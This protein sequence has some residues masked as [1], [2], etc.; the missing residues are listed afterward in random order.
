MTQA[1]AP[2]AMQWQGQLREAE[3]RAEDLLA[4]V[5]AGLAPHLAKELTHNL[6][7]QLAYQR[8]TLLRAHRLAE[9]E[10]VALEMR[11]DKVCR[12]LQ[13]RVSTYEKRTAEL[14]KELVSKTEQTRQLMNATI[15]L[16]QEKVAQKKAAEPFACN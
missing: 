3:Q 13:E 9:Q 6:V 11:F 8:L 15:L 16:T 12:E 2:P 14:E 4:L 7:Q 5:R 1:G 10:I